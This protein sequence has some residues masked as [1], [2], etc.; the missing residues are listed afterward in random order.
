M[1]SKEYDTKVC[2]E[3]YIKLYSSRQSVKKL[4]TS[5]GWLFFVE[6]KLPR[7]NNDF[8]AEC[9]IDIYDRYYI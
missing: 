2:D 7:S 9:N 3:I 5:A 6:L 8:T 4:P 1:V